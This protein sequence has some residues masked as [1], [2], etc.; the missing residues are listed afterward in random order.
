[1]INN[2][3]LYNRVILINKKIFLDLGFN[4]KHLYDIY[5]HGK[6]IKIINFYCDNHREQENPCDRGEQINTTILLNQIV[7]TRRI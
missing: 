4:G 2:E 3:T 5:H 6:I 1:M 7:W